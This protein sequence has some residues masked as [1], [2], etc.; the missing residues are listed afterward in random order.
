MPKPPPTTRAALPCSPSCS[1]SC[2]PGSSTLI[3]DLSARSDGKR[4]TLEG[5]GGHVVEAEWPVLEQ[6]L[7]W[8]AARA[9]EGE[10]RDLVLIQAASGHDIV[11][12]A[13]PDLGAR[14]RTTDRHRAVADRTSAAG[15]R[16]SAHH[17]AHGTGRA[18]ERLP[19]L[20]PDAWPHRLL[21][22]LEVLGLRG[23]ALFH[24]RHPSFTSWSNG[25]GAET[26][27]QHQR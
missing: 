14:H 6:N 1:P 19:N 21:W 22:D 4:T 15:R 13:H 7:A 11:R 8:T 18:D 9:P 2:G 23:V 3:T 20:Q 25:K 12:S 5:G 24:G 27:N 16:E 17:T 26:L 10:T